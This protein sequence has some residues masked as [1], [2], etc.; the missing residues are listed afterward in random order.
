[1]SKNAEVFRRILGLAETLSEG[2]EYA[3]SLLIDKNSDEALEIIYN[4]VD[5]VGSIINA[6]N[7][8]IEQ[9]PTNNLNKLEGAILEKFNKLIDIFSS[10]KTVLLENYI[11]D[12]IM[13]TYIEWK[14]EV[15]RLLTP[16]ILS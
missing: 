1:L 9:F 4:V 13:P 15:K 2:L 6:L 5:G 16:Y 10:P 7:P 3:S 14:S 11:S 12:D 8:Y